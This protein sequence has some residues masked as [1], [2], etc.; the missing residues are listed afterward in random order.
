MLSSGSYIIVNKKLIKTL[1][2][3]EAILLGELCSEYTYWESVNKLDDDNYFYSTRENIQENT[4]LTPYNQRI[5]LKTLE[6]KGIIITQQKGIPCKTY[7]KINEERIIECLQT[8]KNSDVTNFNNKE[9]NNKTSSSENIIEQ[10]VKILNTN[11]NNINNKK[12]NNSILSYQDNG[13]DR[14]DEIDYSDLFKENIEY[15]ILIQDEQ[16]KDLIEDITHVAI[17]TLLSNKKYIQICSEQKPIAVI[18]S[19]LLKL[20]AKHIMYVVNCLKENM[21][22][23]KN[24]KAYL[25]TSLFNAVNTF[26]IDVTLQVARMMNCD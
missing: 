23:V 1:G 15:D 21:N 17:E 2:M 7:Y 24:V 10:D 16:N 3:N 18:K 22:D 25:L 14:I 6:D 11:N 13:I 26:D 9:L 20:K 19:Q 5:S 4:G 12:N 8:A